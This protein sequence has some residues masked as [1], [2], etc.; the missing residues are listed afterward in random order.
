MVPLL[1]IACTRSGSNHLSANDSRTI[2]K[3]WR[4]SI[5]NICCALPPLAPTP[6]TSLSAV[7]SAAGLP[8]NGD[9]TETS[10]VLVAD[11]LRTKYIADKGMWQ[12]CRQVADNMRD[13]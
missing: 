6:I 11:G 2:R 8:I 4:R 13:R 3:R 10:L 5:S 7:S 1:L 12:C 9:D